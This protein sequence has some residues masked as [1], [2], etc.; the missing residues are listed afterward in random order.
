MPNWDKFEVAKNMELAKGYAIQPEV[1]LFIKYEPNL[2]KLELSL[3]NAARRPQS[4][5]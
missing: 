5:Q 1:H 3:T 4:C 2:E